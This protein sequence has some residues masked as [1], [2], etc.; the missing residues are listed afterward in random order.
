MS[1]KKTTMSF[2]KTTMSFKKTTSAHETF[3]TLRS[4]GWR[5]DN[6]ANCNRCGE[7]IEWWKDPNKKW[8]PF[9]LMQRGSQ[10]AIRHWLSCG[11]DI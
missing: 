6:H 8:V 3:D 4:A 7:Q 5:F 1:F 2:K 10:L 11:K 9:N